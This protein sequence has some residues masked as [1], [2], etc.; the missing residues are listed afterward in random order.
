[1]LRRG[2]GQAGSGLNTRRRTTKL[3]DADRPCGRS[4]WIERA[5]PY[6]CGES[7]N[8][9]AALPKERQPKRVR[10]PSVGS[11]LAQASSFNAAGVGSPRLA[12]DEA[13]ADRSGDRVKRPAV[14]SSTTKGPTGIGKGG[15]ASKILR[16]RSRTA[17]VYVG[18]LPR[19]SSF[20]G[21]NPVAQAV[22]KV[23]RAG[24]PHLPTWIGR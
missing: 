9:R 24:R 4:S 3:G 2:N 1:M 22:G 13:G 19:A 11:G 5:R 20:V 14:K 10:I 7:S 16:R 21:G 18:A 12:T 8:R 15:L 23:G 6:W 17:N